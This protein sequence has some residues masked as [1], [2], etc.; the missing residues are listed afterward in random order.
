MRTLKDVLAGSE[1]NE[2]SWIFSNYD[3][4]FCSYF[5]SSVHWRSAQKTTIMNGR[6]YNA[7]IYSEYKSFV[8]IR[9]I[10]I[11][12]RQKE[13]MIAYLNKNEFEEL[14]PFIDSCITKINDDYLKMLQS[15]QDSCSKLAEE[16]FT[17]KFWKEEAQMVQRGTGYY[18]R[19]ML[20]IERQMYKTLLLD[21]T[22]EIMYTEVTKFF[23][24]II[25]LLND[26]IQNL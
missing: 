1:K 12:N 9:F 21:K 26:K 23:D 6:W 17:S 19:L 15:I 7:H 24:G 10:G 20:C 25:E 11:A 2:I 18:N 16:A 8:K 4:S 22:I 13:R 5:R 3:Q 14:K